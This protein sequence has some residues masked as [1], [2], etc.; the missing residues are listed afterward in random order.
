VRYRHSEQLVFDAG[1]TRTVEPSGAGR[2][3]QR[4]SFDLSARY[5]L[6]ETVSANLATRLLLQDNADGSGSSE[7]IYYEVEPALR[8][9]VLPDWF[10][11]ASY[12]YRA[13]ELNAPRSRADS[14]SVTMTLT[15]KTPLW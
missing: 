2:L 3:R 9:E 13:Q 7:R 10:I 14:N 11:A 6:M 8:W 1:Y 5:Q 15:Y 4:D 12:R